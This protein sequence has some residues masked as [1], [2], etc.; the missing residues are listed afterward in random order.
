MRVACTVDDKVATAGL[1]DTGNLFRN[2]VSEQFVRRLGLTKSDIRPLQSGITSLGT[3]KRGAELR[4]LGETKKL[5]SVRLGGSKTIFTFRPVVLEKLGTELILGGPFMQAKGIDVLNSKQCL[6]FQ[7]QTVPMLPHHVFGPISMDDFRIR[8]GVAHVAQTVTIHPREEVVVPLRVATCGNPSRNLLGLIRGSDYLEKTS[9]LHTV[10]NVVNKTDNDG[11]VMASLA[12]TTNRTIK[13]KRDSYY[14]TVEPVDEIQGAT[15]TTRLLNAIFEVNPPTAADPPPPDP[16]KEPEPNVPKTIDEIIDVFKLNDKRALP[17]DHDVAAAAQLLLNNIDLFAFDGR[18]GFTRI[19]KHEIELE[20]GARPFRDKFRPLNPVLEDSFR[21]QLD[22]WLAEDIVRKSKSPW[23]SQLVPVRK[24]NG[25]TRWCVDFRRLNSMTV[26]NAWP[27]GD[28]TDNIAKLSG[29]K[30]FSTVDACS[31]FHNVEILER[32]KE[33][34]AFQTPFGSFEFNRLPFGLCN[35]PATYAR[36]ANEIIEGLPV[37]CALPYL[38]DVIVFSR[39]LKE[40]YRH[41]SL[42]FQAHRQAGLRL[43][44][45]KCSFFRSEA[46]YLGHIVSADGIRPQAPLVKAIADWPYPKSVHEAKVFTAKASYYR[47][48]VPDFAA[49]LAPYFEIQRQGFP[50]NHEFVV[51]DEMKKG[52]DT[53]KKILTSSPLLVYP[54]FR[55]DKP[56]ILDTDFCSSNGSMAAVLSQVQNGS[57]RPIAYAGHRLAVSQRNYSAHKGNLVAKRKTAMTSVKMFMIV[58]SLKHRR[59]FRR[60]ILHRALPVLFGIPEVRAPH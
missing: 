41:L 26:K 18:V 4:I 8:L 9:E 35:A 23:A 49:V 6:R 11:I 52:V 20:A 50:D 45:D 1:I 55:S 53:V 29:S 56:F 42:V 44:P 22:D 40:H 31:A 57:E 37:R 17:H 27:I 15:E 46:E 38:D 13:V 14:G 43:N 54:D 24:K 36:L 32:D 12:N 25:K 28:I 5:L 21:K 2:C 39:T 7:G 30:V 3:A 48:F 33:K 58:L 51:T 34:T 10:R 47:K 59:A 19:L 16:S 60:H